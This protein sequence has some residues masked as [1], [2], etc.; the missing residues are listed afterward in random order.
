MTANV[1]SVTDS[2][3]RIVTFSDGDFTTTNTTSVDVISMDNEAIV[4]M[5][6]GRTDVSSLR[7]NICT[8]MIGCNGNGA[9]AIGFIGGW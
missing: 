8:T 7:S 6:N 5:G 2:T 1:G 3:R 9:E 4:G